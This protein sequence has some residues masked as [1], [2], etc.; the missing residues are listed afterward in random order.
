MAMPW[1][2]VLIWSTG[3]IVARL[4]MPHASPMTFLCWRYAFSVVC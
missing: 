4:A 3:F 2:F 1:V